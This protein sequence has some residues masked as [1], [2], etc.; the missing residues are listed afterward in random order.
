[1]IEHILKLQ[2]FLDKAL[3]G[4]ADVAVL[5]AGCGSTSF[6]RFEQ[7]AHLVGIDIS[8]KQLSRNTSLS[9]TIRGDIQ[10][11]EFQPSTFDIIVCWNVLEH[12]PQPELALERFVAAVKEDGIIV[13][14]LPN[15]LSLKGLLTKCLPY[16]LHVLAHRHLFGRKDAGKDDVGPFKTYL[17][18]SITP[19]AIRESAVNSGLR[20]V[21][22][23]TYDAL[24]ADYLGNSKLA[25]VIYRTL[26]ALTE[27]ASLGRLGDSEFIIVLRKTANR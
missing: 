4:R 16:R 15:V 9:E 8:E 6:F 24:D 18:F 11:Y 19:T 10:Y 22:F 23:D 14:G 1:M 17:R 2:E 21:Y 26:R 20:V 7:T 12:L 27:F 5:E 3:E 25:Y 13:L